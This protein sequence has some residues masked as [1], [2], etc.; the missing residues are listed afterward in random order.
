MISNEIS[1]VVNTVEG[2]K[3]IEDS[4]SLRQT[5]LMN[6]IPYYTTIQGNPNSIK[7]VNDKID[8]NSLQSYFI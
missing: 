1:L 2:I 8:V 3:S 5:A 4:F 6:N 7:S